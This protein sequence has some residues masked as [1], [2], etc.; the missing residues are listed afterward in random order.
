MV[1]R[2][3]YEK[4]P[5]ADFRALNKVSI[6]KSLTAYLMDYLWIAAAIALFTKSSYLIF[7]S[8]LIIGSRQRAL[9]NL[10]HDGSHGNLFGSSDLADAL[11]NLLGGFLMFDTV[12]S[13]RKDHSSHHRHLGSLQNDPDS[14]THLEYGFNDRFPKRSHW[15][16]PIRR[17]NLTM[18][19]LA[20]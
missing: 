12:E 5:Y 20:F 3:V 14:K 9:S 6:S 13:Y 8:L 17:D 16:I 15:S 18:R 7:F 2:E 10:T 19:I 4:N 11:V 1:L